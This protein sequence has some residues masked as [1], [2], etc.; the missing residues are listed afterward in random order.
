MSMTGKDSVHKKPPRQPQQRRTRG[1]G[2]CIVY[3]CGSCGKVI[4]GK[5]ILLVDLC[6][7]DRRTDAEKQL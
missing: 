6:W 2:R 4:M 3:K 1:K 7:C 5:N